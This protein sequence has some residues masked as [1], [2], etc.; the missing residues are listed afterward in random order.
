MNEQSHRDYSIT[1]SL[2]HSGSKPRKL[3]Y[4]HPESRK[5]ILLNYKLA[6]SLRSF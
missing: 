3:H 6:T 5:E 4:W 2:H 1:P